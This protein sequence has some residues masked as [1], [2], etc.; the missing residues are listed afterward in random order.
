MTVATSDDRR[1]E[2]RLRARIVD[3]L[4][5]Q[6]FQIRSGRIVPP[7]ASDKSEIRNLHR[8]AVK[9]NVARS[10]SGLE[11]HEDRLLSYIAAGG[12][13]APER[14][15]PRLVLVQPGSEDE[16]LFRYTRLHW[17]IPVS[18]GYGRR[19]RFV[20]YDESNDKLIGIFGLGDPVFGLEPRD[21]W[22]GW[23]LD[24]RKKRLQCIMDLFVLGAVPPYSYLLCGKLIALLATSLN[25]QE[26]FRQ[27]YGA[28][29]S[30]IS[31]RLLDRRLA[32]LT[33]SS[34]LGRSS[35]YNRLYY[36]ED[37]VFHKVGNTGGSGDFHFSNG[38]YADLQEFALQRCDATAKHPSWGGGFRNRRELVR[39]ALPL[40]GLSSDLLYHGIEREVYAAPLAAN[41]LAFLRGDHQELRRESRSV[42]DLFDWFRERWLLPRA[43]RSERFRVFDPE[44][45]RLWR[46]L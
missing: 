15:R 22:I 30:I 16:L 8:E 5:K 43:G 31:R 29:R 34:A 18:A 41:A 19:L 14:I 2:Q 6:G 38:C 25:V 10:R 33:T 23:D 32:L 27:R 37:R 24:A 12:S 40:L 1:T 3:S 20:V 4:H 11:R 9:H 26:A 45:Y 44:D 13:V 21:R 35:L 17:S 42:D 7:D 28:R 36:R 46:S 39:K